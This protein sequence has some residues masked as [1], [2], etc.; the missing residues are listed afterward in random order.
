MN[1]KTKFGVIGA[2]MIANVHIESIS[3][4]GRGDVTWISSKTNETLQT[5]LK[6]YSIPKGSLD[7]K[8]MLRDPELDIVVISSPPHSSLGYKPP[9]PE[10]IIP[11]T[12]KTILYAN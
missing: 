5:K 6:K 10:S 9:A 7:Y 1:N 11:L 3:K 8:N 12:T 2:G 4:D